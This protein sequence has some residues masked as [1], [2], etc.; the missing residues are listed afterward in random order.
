MVNRKTK[1]YISIY[2]KNGEPTQ[3]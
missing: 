3:H 1:I 2:L